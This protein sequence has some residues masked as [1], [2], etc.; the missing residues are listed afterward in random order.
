MIPEDSTSCATGPCRSQGCVRPGTNSAG[1]CCHG[2]ARASRT[3]EDLL[4]GQRCDEENPGAP[5]GHIEDPGYTIAI[6][7]GADDEVHVTD[8]RVPWVLRFSSAD[9]ALER[10]RVLLR[11]RSGQ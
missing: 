7:V 5:A 11:G 2:C 1:F 9:D 3:G 4:H 10:V 8:T 6:R